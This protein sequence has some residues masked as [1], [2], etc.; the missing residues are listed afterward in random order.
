MDSRNI[1]KNTL[2]VYADDL[3]VVFRA[4]YTERK[5][6][7]GYSYFILKIEK[8]GPFGDEAVAAEFVN[9]CFR[10]GQSSD[11]NGR[12]LWMEGVVLS[13]KGYQDF[14]ARRNIYSV[15]D[16]RPIEEADRKLS[17]MVQNKLNYYDHLEKVLV[18]I[19]EW[20]TACPIRCGV[21]AGYNGIYQ[22]ELMPEMPFLDEKDKPLL[23]GANTLEKVEKD[24]FEL[25]NK[26]DEIVERY[27]YPNG[28]GWRETNRRLRMEEMD[29][30]REAGLPIVGKI[31]F[32]SNDELGSA[33]QVFINVLVRAVHELRQGIQMDKPVKN[34]IDIHSSTESLVATKVKKEPSGEIGRPITILYLLKLAVFAVIVMTVYKYFL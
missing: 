15:L 8:A 31:Y 10:L 19:P 14:M 4:E 3:S 17:N 24:F 5:D 30:R 29:R 22:P 25:M 7:T 2:Y 23:F 28:G 12:F 13:D 11:S 16:L 20:E 9:L 34:G 33:R 27:E 32:E 1:T 26:I 21:F 18:F 6:D